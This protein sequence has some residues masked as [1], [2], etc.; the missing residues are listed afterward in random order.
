MNINADKIYKLMEEKNDLEFIKKEISHKF[1]R[2]YAD[3]IV[4]FR[5]REYITDLLL[6]VIK[7]RIKELDYEINKVEK[8][9]KTIK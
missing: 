7:I 1:F 9:L 8:R 2:R 3:E 4:N 5:N 6:R